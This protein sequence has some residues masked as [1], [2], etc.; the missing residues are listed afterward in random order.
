VQ[1][2]ERK[3]AALIPSQYRYAEP[4]KGLLDILQSISNR[5]AIPGLLETPPFLMRA[6]T[7]NL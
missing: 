3:I 5:H 6:Q 4:Y 2:P 7:A 1:A